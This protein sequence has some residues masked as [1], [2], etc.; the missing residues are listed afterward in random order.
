[1]TGAD[2]FPAAL[3]MPSVDLAALGIG[4]AAAG[5]AGATAA[6]EPTSGAG[7]DRRGFLRL[8]STAEV[9]ARELFAADRFGSDAIL[10]PGDFG[11]A[12]LS[13]TDAEG[14][15]ELTG[16]ELEVSILGRTRQPENPLRLE[17]LVSMLT[18]L[19]S[20][21]GGLDVSI[22]PMRTTFYVPSTPPSLPAGSAPTGGRD[23]AV[24]TFEYLQSLG[25]LSGDYSVVPEAA[26]AAPGLTQ[27]DLDLY[28]WARLQRAATPGVLYPPLIDSGGKLPWGEFA[29]FATASFGR[30]A[31]PSMVLLIR[32]PP[33]A[34][35]PYHAVCLYQVGK[36]WRWMD[37]GTF[38]DK[39]TEDWQLLPARIEGKDVVYRV[40]DV[41]R[42]WLKNTVD[43]S[44]GWLIS[45]ISP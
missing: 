22:V 18:T 45:R 7:T 3:R 21:V 14:A 37:S 28:W 27:E 34:P 35:V 16:S 30:T 44:S 19:A 17:E 9:A 20:K 24:Q 10:E 15:H 5:A 6:A 25:L 43:E 42:E 8:W 31:T 40:V 23:P 33:K 12:I 11:Q 36:S 1:M 2:P 32:R 26:V 38:G 4:T 29:L 41:A 13:Y 39:S